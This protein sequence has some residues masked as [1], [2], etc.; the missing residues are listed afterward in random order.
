[1]IQ[2]VKNTIQSRIQKSWTSAKQ[3][4]DIYTT[5]T[6]YKKTCMREKA[7]PQ[8]YTFIALKTR[9]EITPSTPA[10]CCKHLTNQRK[11]PNFTKNPIRACALL[12]Y[13]SD[14]NIHLSWSMVEER[15]KVLLSASV[16][17][18]FY[19]EILIS[20]F[21]RKTCNALK[22]VLMRLVSYIS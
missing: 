9:I 20:H 8:I 3:T 17:Q 14:K 19:T 11:S 22:N 5:K 13:T 21:G 12:L 15:M 4:D 6:D 7:E 18:P 1:M 10:K 16:S 2:I